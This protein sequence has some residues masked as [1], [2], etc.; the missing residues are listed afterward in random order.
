MALEDVSDRLPPPPFLAALLDP[1]LLSALRLLDI[2][3]TTVATRYYRVRLC[4]ISSNY[5]TVLL[6]VKNCV[7]FLLAGQRP[8]QRPIKGQSKGFPLFQ[9]ARHLKPQVNHILKFRLCTLSF[10][11]CVRS[12]C[13][14]HNYQYTSMYSVKGMT[15]YLF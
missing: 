14:L 10:K 7:K 2:D 6:C 12:K 11:R 15:P 3:M 8:I 1:L 9:Q 5:S 4:S 13:M